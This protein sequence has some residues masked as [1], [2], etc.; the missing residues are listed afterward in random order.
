MTAALASRPLGCWDSSLATVR[1]QARFEWECREEQVRRVFD[2]F[3]TTH[4]HGEG[5][6]LGMSITHSI[7]EE[8]RGTI[9]VQSSP[10]EGTTVTVIL[11]GMCRE[12]DNGISAAC[13]P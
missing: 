13:L 6:G 7:V 4:L 9:E 11:H 2:P 3:Y 10:E 1:N 8:H 12:G 5:T